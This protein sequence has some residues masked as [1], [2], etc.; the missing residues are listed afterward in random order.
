MK[1]LLALV[2]PP[3]LAKRERFIALF[4]AAEQCDN[5][6]SLNST[7]SSGW[8]KYWC[9]LN[10]YPIP[11]DSKFWVNL[12]F[13]S[14]W[15]CIRNDFMRIQ[16][17]TVWTLY[18]CQSVGRPSAHKSKLR[19]IGLLVIH[20][21]GWKSSWDGCFRFQS[22]NRKSLVSRCLGNQNT[23][24]VGKSQPT[25]PGTFINLLISHTKGH[26]E[27]SQTNAA[28]RAQRQTPSVNTPLRMLIFV[29]QFF[30]MASSASNT[31]DPQ[32]VFSEKLNGR[33]AMIGLVIGLAV[34]AA[35]GKG[36]IQQVWSFNES[37]KGIDFSGLLNFFSWPR[38]CAEA[39]AWH[40]WPSSRW[41]RGRSDPASFF[42]AESPAD[43]LTGNSF[44]FDGFHCLHNQ[45]KTS[46]INCFVVFLFLVFILSTRH[47]WKEQ[48]AS[49]LILLLSSR[50]SDDWTF[51]FSSEHVWLC[52][53]VS[54]LSSYAIF[55]S[56]WTKRRSK[57]FC[58]RQKNIWR[59]W[60]ADQ[61]LTLLTSACRR[62]A[63]KVI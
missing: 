47:F 29:K 36:I 59:S 37:T 22:I 45:A 53:I 14:P 58:R 17:F 18:Q 54:I 55:R 32:K 5:S 10:C 9:L 39:W 21:N 63:E 34:E 8:L 57:F 60:A 40:S 30:D 61:V 41:I 20:P 28:L 42:Y 35:T 49:G 25:M 27:V 3:L 26:C 7:T 19:C 56:L 31:P 38:P 46:G 12:G 43:S 13:A 2:W 24:S 11:I 48:T 15:Q 4:E 6:E 44:K 51:S 16:T 52:P 23:E 1:G 62:G 50:Q 33:A